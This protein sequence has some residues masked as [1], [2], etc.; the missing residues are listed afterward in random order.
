MTNVGYLPEF[1]PSSLADWVGAVANLI[2]VLA[3]FGV[4]A[5]QQRFDRA[6]ELGRV[7]ATGLSATANAIAAL[8]L[9]AEI[10]R[11]LEDKPGGSAF[12][13]NGWQFRLEIAAD[14]MRVALGHEHRDPGLIRSLIETQAWVSFVLKRI[15]EPIWLWSRLSISNQERADLSDELKRWRV[16]Q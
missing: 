12:N 14:T 9:I 11:T 6:R 7:G 3:A 13:K 15:Q 5:I 1:A 4:V 8:D 2:V 16:T 10:E